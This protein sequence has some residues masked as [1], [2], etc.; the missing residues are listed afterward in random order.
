MASSVI[1]SGRQVRNFWHVARRSNQHGGPVSVGQRPSTFLFRVP[2]GAGAATHFNQSP[3]STA[4]SG[5][6]DA[7]RNDGK[8]APSEGLAVEADASDA[9]SNNADAPSKPGDSRLSQLGELSKA[10][11]SALVV[12]TTAFGFL[13]A[14]PAAL[15][16]T[17]IPTFAAASVGTAL[18]ASSAATFNQVLE[19][20]RDRRMRRT[21]N[22]PLVTGAVSKEAAAALGCLT[23]TSGGLLLGLGTDPVTTMLGVGNIGLYAGLYTYLKPRSEVNTWVGAVVGAVPPVMGWTAAG[24]SPFDAEAVLLGSTLFLWQFPHFFALN[25]MYRADYKRGGFAMVAVNDP[26][27]D[28]TA[29]IIKRYGLYLASLPFVSTALEVTSPMFAVDGGILLNG[30]ALYVASKFDKERSNANARKVFLTSLW[31]LPCVM[32]LFLLHSRRWHG[33]VTDDDSL[34]LKNGG[35]EDS[36]VLVSMQKLMNEIQSKGRDLCVH[37]AIANT[38]LGIRVGSESNTTAI[39]GSKCPIS[40]GK[41]VTDSANSIAAKE[42]IQL[43]QESQSFK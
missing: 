38:E 43:K 4:A 37:E 35:T 6:E 28:R 25:W 18:C 8:V 20:E 14:G 21:A 29:N 24:G 30:Y 9:Q 36:S 17:S 42:E 32:M 10:R 41:A 39:D 11:L 33:E 2:R 13:S 23:G 22:R 40:L 5:G 15:A 1:I 12:S 16:Y 26:R 3:F 31:Y 7:R 34:V 27:G 19:V